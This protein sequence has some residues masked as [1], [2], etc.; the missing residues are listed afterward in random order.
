MNILNI[1]ISLSPFIVSLPFT[2]LDINKFK[3]EEKVALLQPP[4]LFLVSYGQFYMFFYLF[5]IIHCFQKY[6]VVTYSL[7]TQILIESLQGFWL[8]TFRFNDDGRTQLQYSN[9]LLFYF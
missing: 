3:S 2:L 4:D 6:A 5:L 9:E 7:R 8:Y 1:I